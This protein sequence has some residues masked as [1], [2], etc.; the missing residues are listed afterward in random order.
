M[1]PHLY[2]TLPFFMFGFVLFVVGLWSVHKIRQEE[3][4]KRPAGFT[5]HHRN[6][7]RTRVNDRLDISQE[8]PDRLRY[9]G[10]GIS[11]TIR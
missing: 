6:L 2:A 11:L 9:R 7:A 5:A 4:A 8:A 1:N 10:T 3:A